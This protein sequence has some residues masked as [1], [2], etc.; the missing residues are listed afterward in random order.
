MHVLFLLNFFP[1]DY[2]GGAEISA[3]HTCRG[4]FDKGMTCS[5]LVVN[6]RLSEDKNES[7]E[8]NG[9]QVRQ[10]GFQRRNR[11]AW[12]DVFDWRI[13]RTVRTELRRL[14]PD[15]VHI[16]NVS[17]ATLA[18]YVACRMMGVPVVN[19]LHDL[20]LL[21]PNNM[22]YRQDGSFCDPARYPKVCQKCFRRYDFWG[23]IPH[24]RAIF[25]ALTANVK[26]FISPSQG[27]IDQHVRAGYA[28]GS[29][30]LVPYGVI[31]ERL[32]EP[33][34]PMVLEVIDSAHAYRTLVFAGGG[35]EIKGAAV[36]IEAIPMMLRH[37]ER[38]RI[39]VAGTGEERFLAQFRQ[40]EPAVRFV[41]RVTFKEMRK[42]FAVADLTVVPSVWYENSPV[43]IYE[44]FQVGTPVVGS[45]FG[46]IPE[47]ICEGKTG[48]LF[49]VGDAAELAEKVILHFA[50]PSRE[51]RRMRQQ[52]IKQARS[53]LT[54]ENHVM[55]VLQVYQE[56]LAED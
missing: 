51:R 2:V 39:V 35:V 43:V 55:A 50:R 33:E 38:L 21:C 15:L 24:R 27:L 16:H 32:T 52:C 54:M 18:P 22:L 37:V 46:G 56:T 23:N 11:W 6:N 36:L 47:L 17:G 28:P 9:I 7:Y 40:Y 30:R 41:G 4:L 13:F 25:A 44:N 12:R 10:V 42:L 53:R 26:A 19:T 3:Y 48:Y 20:W 8:L 14:K 29:F 45:A 49:P 31:D 1:P 34:H 5:V